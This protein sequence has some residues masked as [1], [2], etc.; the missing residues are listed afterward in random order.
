MFGSVFAAFD[1][2]EK[3]GNSASVRDGR[4]TVQAQEF[5]DGGCVTGPS[6]S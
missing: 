1:A 6:K 4:S 2:T 5:P 3:D